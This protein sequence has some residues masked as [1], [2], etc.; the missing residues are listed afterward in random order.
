MPKLFVALGLPGAVTAELAQIQPLRAA[1]VRLARP[2]QMH[3][4]L[5]YIGQASVGRMAAALQG[6]AVPAFTVTVEGVGQF[7]SADGTVTLWAGVQGAGGLLDL[8]R[9]VADALAP[10]GFRP[11]ARPYNPHVTLARCG[12]GAAAGA[13]EDFLARNRRFSLPAFPVAA[14]GLYSSVLVRDAPVYRRE[15]VFSL[16][17]GTGGGSGRPNDAAGR[18]APQAPT[19]TSTRPQ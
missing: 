19:I 11:E 9:A 16:R 13:V 18:G 4:T 7:R 8:H 6:V 14:F 3:L 1:G 17:A 12:P 15:R 5:H 2:G 10:E